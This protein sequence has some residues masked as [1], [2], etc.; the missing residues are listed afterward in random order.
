M[1]F[2]ENNFFGIQQSFKNVVIV[3]E[4]QT[5]AFKNSKNI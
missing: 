3:V 4:D 1:K 5:K 2:I